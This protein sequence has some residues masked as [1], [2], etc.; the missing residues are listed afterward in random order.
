MSKQIPRIV[1]LAIG[2]QHSDVEVLKSFLK[3]FGYYTEE[4]TK[5]ASLRAV[6]PDVFDLATELALKKYQQ[7]HGLPETGKFD[8][9]TAL[10]VSQ[11]RCGV[12]DIVNIADFVLVGSKW[13]HSNLTFALE[14]IPANLSSDQVSR[15]LHQAGQLWSEVTVLSIYEVGITW[16]HDFRI[17]FVSGDHGDGSS[18][19][20]SGNVLAHAFFPPPKGGDLP[21]DVHFDTAE[22]WQVILPSP[23]G[24]FDL[25][26]VA[27]H[28]FG[29]SVGLE[30]S[31]VPGALMFPTYSGPHRYLSEDDVDG[32]RA[33]YGSFKWDGG[34]WWRLPDPAYASDIGAGADG[35]VWVAGRKTGQGPGDVTYR[36][37][38]ANWT[39][40]G[41]D[42]IP[43]SAERI[44]VGPDG[45][46]W[47]VNSR[48][49]IYQFTNGSWQRRP[50][51][52]YDIGIGA[53]G[54]VWVIGENQIGSP[55]VGCGIYRW[56]GSD[57]DS[58]PGAGWRIAVGPDGIPWTVNALGNI[59]KWTGSDWQ[60]KPG[61]ARDVGVGGGWLSL[62]CWNGQSRRRIW[63]IQMES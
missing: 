32:I 37:H 14:N 21:G 22:T 36:L 29:H 1:N 35:S 24:T 63:D 47:M 2:A 27:A 45:N 60:V 28:E 5:I 54:A 55:F 53:N 52:A 9:A 25:A 11:P 34:Q 39:E 46:P 7:F 10:M 40:T 51:S 61:T 41:W 49:E 16:A 20:G 23:P 15:S 43:G 48:L 19:D 18:F 30:H 6:G 62:D 26:T 44:A 3:R 13:D 56:N 8:E 31:N 57:W 33:I 50:G 42:S 59:Y 17:R 12:P 4:I 58:C 38:Y